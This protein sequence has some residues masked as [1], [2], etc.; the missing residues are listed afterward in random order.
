MEEFVAKQ[1]VQYGLLGLSG[2]LLG[3]VVWQFRELL[4]A[5]KAS[6]QVV[7]ANTRAVSELTSMTRDLLLLNRSMHD[8]LL[9][10]RGQKN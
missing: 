4:G 5:L 9:M 6:D 2:A 1:V 7:A 3:I 10:H 8:M